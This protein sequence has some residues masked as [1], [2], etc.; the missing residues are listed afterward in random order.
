MVN[1]QPQK[2]SCFFS[3]SR[4]VPLLAGEYELDRAKMLYRMSEAIERD[5]ERCPEWNP[6]A[7]RT[8]RNAS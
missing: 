2:T 6:C 3:Q 5:I 1:R 4:D 7:F 8:L